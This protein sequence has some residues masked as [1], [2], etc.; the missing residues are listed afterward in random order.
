MRILLVAA[1]L[2]APA[3]AHADQCALNDA[4]VNAN[5]EKLVTVGARVLEFCEPCREKTPGKPYVVKS[6]EVKAREVFINGKGQ[7]LA[8]LYVERG[9][10]EFKNVGALAGC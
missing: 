9:K 1:A 6:V 10:D 3:L 8:Y 4:K 2:V 5:A 7:D